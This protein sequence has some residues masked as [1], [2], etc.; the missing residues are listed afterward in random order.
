MSYMYPGIAKLKKCFCQ[1]TEFN[2]NLDLLTNN[3]AFEENQFEEADEDDE[4]G[5]RRKIKSNTPV[6]T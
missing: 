6:N 3:H 2:N 1:T 4:S 5:A